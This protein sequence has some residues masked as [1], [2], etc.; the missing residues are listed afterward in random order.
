MDFSKAYNRTRRLGRF[1][2]AEKLYSRA[3]LYALRIACIGV[4]VGG[5]AAAGILHGPVC[6]NAGGCTGRRL[7]W[8]RSIFLYLYSGDTL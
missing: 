6:R 2:T 4:L 3:W 5:F 8:N 1:H 7:L